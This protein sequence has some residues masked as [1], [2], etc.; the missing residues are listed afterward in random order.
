M[1]L[2][3]GATLHILHVVQPMRAKQLSNVSRKVIG[4]LH[5]VFK[6]AC[7]QLDDP[8][9]KKSDLKNLKVRFEVRMG[10]FRNTITTFETAKNIDVTILGTDQI[11]DVNGLKRGIRGTVIPK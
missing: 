11:T 2:A 6:I 8:I 1:A 7:K 5:I 3:N 9:F 10:A 4:M